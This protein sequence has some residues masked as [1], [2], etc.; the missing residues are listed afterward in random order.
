MKKRILA[1]LLCAVFVSAPV[2][3]NYIGDF[4]KAGI[5]VTSNVMKVSK[6]A[7]KLGENTTTPSVTQTDHSLFVEST[8]E[9]DGAVRL[10]NSSLTLRGVAF[11]LPAADGGAGATLT[12][13]GSGVL[14][15]SAAGAGVTLDGAYDQGGA[16]VGRTITASDG[17]VVIQNTDADTTNILEINKSPSGPAAGAGIAVTVGANGTGA[18]ISFANSGSGND[19]LGTGS[20]WSVSKAGTATFP[21]VAAT[22]LSTTGTTTLGNNIGTV[23]VRSTSWDISTTGAISGVTSLGLSDDITLANG[24]AVKGSITNAETIAIQSYDVDGAAYRNSILLTNG[25]T[26]AIAIG[27]NNET[28]AI[29]SSDWDISTTGAMTGI[30]AI[31]MDGLLTGTAGATLSGAAINLNVDSNFAVNVGTGTTT[32]TVTIGG[33]GAQ[34]IDIGNGAAAK[35]VA[36]GSSNSTSTTTLLSGSGGVLVN[37]SNN[38]PTS[39]NSGTSTGTVTIGNAT[40]PAVVTEV[41]TITLNHD[42]AAMTTGI[43]TGTTTGTVTIGGAGAQTVSVGNGAAA[44]T[45]N[46]GSSNTTSTT[47]ILSGSGGILLNKDNNQPTEIGTGTTTGT[48]TVGGAGAQTVTIA[49]GAAAKTLNLG[50]T[51]TTSTTNVY[52]GS[53]AI[54]LLAAVAGDGSDT[55]V[56]FLRTVVD[57]ADGEAS[58]GVAESGSIQT[59]AGAGGAA[60]WVLPAA[61]PGL[62]FTFVVM[63]AQELRVTPAAGD[64]INIAGSQGDAAEYWTA[65]V[66]GGSLTLIAVDANNWV[67]KCFTGTWAQQTP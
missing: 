48:V 55:M 66:V 51:N 58:L 6:K 47:T 45:V 9:V 13:N 15:W 30:G 32:S 39:I 11:T 60:A 14:S 63:A 36:L 31:T 28:V 25:N 52:A 1:F 46:V 53:G 12:T 24:K 61:A 19:L 17:A 65:N 7:L 2:W 40:G 18:G 4:I 8:L 26:P 56:G 37:A 35:T 29:N 59:N 54:N 67:A 49:N 50:S 22:A 3:A 21:S 10:D 44:K 5:D 34:S 38:Q 27:T 62:E 33:A 57:D 20:L 41:G 23:E 64:A 43:G 16:G 42:A